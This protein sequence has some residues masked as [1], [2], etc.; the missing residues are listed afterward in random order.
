[1]KHYGESAFMRQYPLS[2]KKP[3][4]KTI[5]T[6]CNPAY[7]ILFF[8]VG[9][10]TMGLF[11]FIIQ[12]F[13]EVYER[14]VFYV[15]AL[16]ALMTVAILTVIFVI[17]WYQK[18]YARTYFYTIT[19]SLLVIRKGVVAPREIT[20][21]FGRIQ[22]I[23]LDQDPIDNMFSLYD[24]HISTATAESTSRAHIDGVSKGTAEALRELIL[25]KM[26]E[27]R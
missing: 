9:L 19:D 1:M 23:Y 4:V 26:K 24:V 10:G 11:S 13:T 7:W 21:P 20:V 14:G 6:V 3:M 25:H 15:Y 12:K 22:D 18:L 8:G 27:N 5:K 17:Y 2:P 16:I